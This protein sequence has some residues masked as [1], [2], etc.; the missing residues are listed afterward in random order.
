MKLSCCHIDTCLCDFWSGYHLPHVQVAVYRGMTPQALREAI[1]NELRMG[2]VMGSNDDA[3]LLSADQ[4]K[5][6]EEKRADALRRAAYAAVNRDV[7]P[8]K[9][10]TRRLFLDLEET[11]DDDGEV[12]AYFVFSEG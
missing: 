2:A 3:R 9:K 11:A 7:R 1:H 6:E 5:P 8:A 10:G 12:Y 4:V